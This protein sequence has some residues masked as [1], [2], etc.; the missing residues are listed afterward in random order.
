MISLKLFLIS[1]VLLTQ[2]LNHDYIHDCREES[3]CTKI[4]YLTFEE[5]L[6]NLKKKSLIFLQNFTRY[7]SPYFSNIKNPRDSVKH[8]QN[9]MLENI[10]HQ[11]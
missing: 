11:P 8:P 2:L 10:F 5:C 3:V 4:D 6:K 9:L 7:T 1:Y